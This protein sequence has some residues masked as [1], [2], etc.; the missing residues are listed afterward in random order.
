MGKREDDGGNGGDGDGLAGRAMFFSGYLIPVSERFV[1]LSFSFSS[2][3]FRPVTMPN[4]SNLS[5]RL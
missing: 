3:P 2:L 4:Q 1:T 5:R